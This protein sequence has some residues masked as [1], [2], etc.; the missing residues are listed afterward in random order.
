ML[1]KMEITH[2]PRITLK[3]TRGGEQKNH[4]GTNKKSKLQ[5]DGQVHSSGSGCFI[6]TQ[7]HGR[8]PKRRTEF[9][10]RSTELI[11]EQAWR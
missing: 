4:R 8:K 5:F 11:Q 7:L 2:S 6:H 10:L 3:T 1:E 9:A